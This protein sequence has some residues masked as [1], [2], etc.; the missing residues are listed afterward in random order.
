MLIIYKIL[1]NNK[2]MEKLFIL[3][4]KYFNTNKYSLRKYDILYEC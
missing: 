3:T 1:N 2:Q 4:Y